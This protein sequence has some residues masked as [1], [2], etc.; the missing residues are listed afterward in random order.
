MSDRTMRCCTI[1]SCQSAATSDIVK[2]CIRS[3]MAD[4]QNRTCCMLA[5]ALHS[6]KHPTLLSGKGSRLTLMVCLLPMPLWLVDSTRKDIRANCSNAVHRNNRLSTGGQITWQVITQVRSES[7]GLVLH[8]Q[9]IFATLQ[10]YLY[11]GL[12]CRESYIAQQCIL[13][14]EQNLFLVECGI[15]RFLC[16]MRVLQV[17]ASS[18][19]PRLPLCQM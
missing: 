4:E 13:C 6:S 14:C 8:A 11:N 18:S 9:H 1:R 7:F 16:A 3:R 2:H 5:N 19:S 17:R 10:V 15:A 12:L